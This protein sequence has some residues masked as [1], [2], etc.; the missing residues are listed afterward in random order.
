M[1]T[2]AIPQE[3]S[4][5]DCC[6]RQIVYGWQPCFAEMPVHRRC[7][8]TH[9][10][11]GKTW[12]PSFKF[13]TGTESAIHGLTANAASGVTTTDSVGD[14]GVFV[15]GSTMYVAPVTSDKKPANTTKKITAPDSLKQLFYN[16]STVTAIDCTNLDTSKVKTMEGVF[17]NCNKLQTV[18]ISSFSTTAGNLNTIFMFGSCSSLKTIYASSSFNKNN[19]TSDKNMFYGCTS[20]VGGNGTSFVAKATDKTYACIDKSGQKGY[21]T[22]KTS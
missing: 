11:F 3:I 21:F 19:I 13:V 1:L 20:L 12:L 16:N 6:S 22:E 4:I 9:C 8:P 15:V 14:V 17:E 5:K 2:E 18:D 7:A 10:H